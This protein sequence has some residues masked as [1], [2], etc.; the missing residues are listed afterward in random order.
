MIRLAAVQLERPMRFALS[1]ADV[2]AQGGAPPSHLTSDKYDL[3]FD[4]DSGLVHI[5]YKGSL[6]CVHVSQTHWLEPTQV[7]AAEP[8]KEHWKTRKKREEA[9]H[10]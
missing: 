5:S 10:D 6:R 4:S 9:A 2:W 8:K 3:A 7:D 1:P